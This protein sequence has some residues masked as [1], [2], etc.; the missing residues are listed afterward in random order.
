MMGKYLMGLA[1][2]FFSFCFLNK[3]FIHCMELELSFLFLSSCHKHSLTMSDQYHAV[4]P[5]LS[6]IPSGSSPGLVLD[7]DETLSYTKL[8]WIRELQRLFGNPENIPAEELARKYKLAQD[9]PYWK[10]NPEALKWMDVTRS[11]PEAQ[12]NLP[13]IEGA[14][15]GVRQL[16]DIVPVYGYLTI[17]PESVSMAT[18]S[19]LSDVGFPDLPVI[20]RP[21]FV[22]FMEGNKWKACVL[23]KLFPHVRGIVDDSPSV[24]RNVTASYPGLVFLFDHDRFED[25]PSRSNVVPSKT[26]TD[27]LENVRNRKEEGCFS[28]SFVNEKSKRK[29]C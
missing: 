3:F 9:A 22:N 2:S 17:R 29:R 16:Q 18:K 4:E 21:D 15:E 5:F 20:S 10:E 27:V 6:S 26:W 8:H 1:L 12:L 24:A 25:D 13:L 28:S 19:W 11:N 14:L 7:I 23:H